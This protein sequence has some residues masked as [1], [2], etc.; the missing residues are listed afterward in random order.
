MYIKNLSHELGRSNTLHRLGSGILNAIV[1]VP[2]RLLN[3]SIG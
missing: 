1:I 3:A 2:L